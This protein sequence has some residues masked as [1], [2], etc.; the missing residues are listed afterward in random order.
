MEEYSPKA[1]SLE[2]VRGEVRRA[3]EAHGR[4]D[5]EG[6][7]SIKEIFTPRRGDDDEER[8][9]Q[10]DMKQ[11]LLALSSNAALLH[12]G[13]SGLVG[14]VLACEW[15]GRDEGFVKA[16]VHFLGSLASAQGMYV[17]SVLGM[18]VG[19][20]PGGKPIL[21][22]YSVYVLTLLQYECLAAVSQVTSSSIADNSPREFMLL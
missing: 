2:S 20:F 14:A 11:Y 4:G 5:S 12:R 18:L 3:I 22:A 16:Y 13:C 15:M 1:R 19:Y 21:S 8:E 17:G 9:D 7:D 10:G 6:Y